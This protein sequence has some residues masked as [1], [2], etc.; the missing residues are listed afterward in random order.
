MKNTRYTIHPTS[1]RGTSPWSRGE[2]VV[3]LL[4]GIAW[5][6][7][8]GWTP[9]PLNG[10]R[11]FWLRV[12]GCKVSGKPFVH[13]R[14]RIEMPW[15]VTLH[16][17]AC[18]GDRTSLYSLGDIEL[19]ANAVVAQEAYLCGGTH[20]FNDPDTPL[21]TAKITIGADAF[22]GCR[23]FIMPGVCVGERALVGA[24]ALVTDHVE[25]GSVVAGN[26]ARFLRMRE[27]AV[28]VET[29]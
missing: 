29:L 13:Q 7:L 1:P 22:I 17:K 28:L 19:C 12:F 3:L 14:A 27:E 4:W 6:V 21:L 15:H 25:A 20:D 23:A 9:K 2:R 18:V 10:W 24:C 5:P 16:D 8:C 26:P 11:L